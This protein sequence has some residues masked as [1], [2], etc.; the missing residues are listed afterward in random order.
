M[1]N[2]GKFRLVQGYHSPGNY[3]R[4]DYFFRSGKSQVM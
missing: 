3:L 4:N 2:V 1:V